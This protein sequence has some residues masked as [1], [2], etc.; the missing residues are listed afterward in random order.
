MK[1]IILTTLTIILLTGCGN[2]IVCKTKDGDVS[3]NYTITYK[4]NEITSIENEKKYKFDN[5]DEFNSFEKII[6][7]MTTQ[8]K[9]ENIDVS[10]K[11]KNKKYILT[12]KY[13][14]KNIE[15]ET[16]KKYGLSKNKEELINNLKNNGLTC[17]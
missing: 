2:K 17:K 10:Y 13:D 14:I 11:K 4:E 6:K 5:K 1:R 3:E 8:N 12:Q 15:E 16:L 7:K 9:N